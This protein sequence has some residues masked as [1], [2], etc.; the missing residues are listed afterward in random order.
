MKNFSTH[1]SPRFLLILV[2]SALMAGCA[3]QTERGTP[4]ALPEF[5]SN[6][7]VA[8][9]L[10]SDALPNSRTLLPPPPAAGSVAFALDEEFSKKSFAL[11]DTPAWEL[12]ALDADLS[13]PNAAGAF[14]CA[15]N[16]PV[17]RQETP[18]LY[19]LLQR[20]L[21]DA[22]NSTK[23][24]KQ[25]YQRPRPFMVNHEPICSPGDRDKLEKSGSYPSGHNAAGMTWALILAEISPQQGEAILARGRAFGISRVVCNVH[26]HSDTQQGR[27][28]GAYT[29]ARLH[30][31]PAFRADLEAAKAELEA[32][33][34]KG[35]KS[36]RDC[37]AETAGVELQRSLEQ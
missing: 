9:Y 13:F 30:A 28:M 8:G 1:S 15:L 37:K 33:R 34:A 6:E 11:R 4:A 29:V 27:Y 16:A 24:A 25:Y 14:S 19:T 21:A 20:T 22:G 12:A 2:C 17:T 7:R 5:R 36:T 23:A 32:V 18:H 26:W 31:D 10:S 35:L 3:G